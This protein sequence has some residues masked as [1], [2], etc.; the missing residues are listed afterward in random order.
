MYRRTAHHSGRSHCAVLRAHGFGDETCCRH[1]EPRHEACRKAVLGNDPIL[2]R[3]V[4]IA[5]VGE[6]I[7]RLAAEKVTCAGDECSGLVGVACKYS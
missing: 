7:H 1:R 5:H 4:K 6:R 2:E 3:A